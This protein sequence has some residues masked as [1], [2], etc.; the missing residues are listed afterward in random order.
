MKQKFARV[1]TLILVAALFLSFSLSMQADAIGLPNPIIESTAEEAAQASGTTGVYLIYDD[2][3]DVK[4]SYIK[5][6][7]GPVV[8]QAQFA[9]RGT[10]CTFRVFK[11]TQLEDLSGMNYTWAEDQKVMVSVYQGRM[12]YNEGEVG[13]L[14]W[15]DVHNE[16]VYSISM[17]GDVTPEKMFLLAVSNAGGAD[18]LIGLPNPVF[19]ATAEEAAQ[20]SGTPGAKLP[21]D[22]ED[23]SYYYIK[24]QDG[25][26]I[27]QI[28]FVWEGSLCTIRVFKGTQLED[29]SGLHYVSWD[30]DE[31]VMIGDHP[32]RI[33]FQ[34]DVEGTAMWYDAN[35]GLVY[36]VMMGG[37]ASMENLMKLALVNAE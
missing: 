17:T 35:T 36:N 34:E 22:A 29:L 24:G 23:P 13:V 4:Y 15:Y 28:N 14:M 10:D 21:E 8:F 19:E 33:K 12:A 32:G 31:E 20:A 9:W 1:I 3:K 11:G 7:E 5:G 27:F 18:D 6:K 2:I 26:V 16:Q 37:N 25:L 30:Q